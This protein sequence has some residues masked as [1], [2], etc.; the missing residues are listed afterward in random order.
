M[1]LGFFFRGEGGAMAFAVR[2]APVG[3]EFAALFQHGG[4]LR[5]RE[6]FEDGG[7]GK[8]DPFRGVHFRGLSESGTTKRAADSLH[9][10]RAGHQI[11][12]RIVVWW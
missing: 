8:L 6:I 10:H 1:G 11:G 5:G 2:V 7:C 9:G 4:V 12:H 3:H